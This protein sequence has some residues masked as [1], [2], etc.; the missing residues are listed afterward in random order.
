[1]NSLK[2]RRILLIDDMPPIHEDFRKI[3]VGDSPVSELD[4]VEAMLFGT[5][6]DT[7]F[8]GFELDS[9]YQG[10]DGMEMVQKSLD[11]NLPYAMAFIDMRMPP[12]WDGVETTERLWQLDP[13][14]QIVIC[15]AYSD[16]SW[17]EVLTRLDTRDRLL[18]LKKPFDLIEV[19]QLANT[20]TAKWVSGQQAALKMEYLEQIVQERTKE[21]T[22]EMLVRK[23]AQASLEIANHNLQESEEQYRLLVE[24]SPDA[25]LI[26]R[27]ERV[28]FANR[29]ACDMFRVQQID[30]LLNRSIASLFVSPPPSAT[31]HLSTLEKNID[32]Q[33]LA[34]ELVLC[35]D[36]DEIHV[37]VTRLAYTY[38]GKSATQ[39]V[40]RDA[41][42]HK[43]VQ[44][45]LQYQ[46]NYDAL[47]GLPNR[48]LLMDRLHQ[49]L[50]HAQ[51]NEG[52]L[53]ICFL[54]LDRFKWI[55]DNL[56]HAAG[57]ELLKIVA[58]R[59]GACLRE[60]DTI[61]RLGGDE[62]VLL[63]YNQNGQAYDV[64]LAIG[65]VVK[66]VAQP[67]IL[68]G[69][70]VNISCS[71]G[72]SNFPEDGIDGN[73]LLKF[74]DAAMYRAKKMGRNNLQ[75]YNEN[76]H[77]HLDE[78]KK[79][80][81]DLQRAI[82][83]R[84]LSLAYQ[85]QIDLR[86]GKIIGAE[87]LLRWQHPELGNISPSLFLP[88]AE[89]T[90]LIE[91][92]GAWTIRTVCEQCKEWREAD[93]PTLCIS[94]NLSA[95]QVEWPD[96]K[97][98]I[99]DCLATNNIEPCHIELELAE[100]TIVQNIEKIILIMNDL[101][102]L[103]VQ[104]AIDDFGTGYSNL[105]SLAALPIDKIK[106]DGSFINDVVS[107]PDNLAIANTIIVMAH[108]L[109]LK[110]V[111]EMVETAGQV[112]LLTLGG[113]DQAQGYFFSPALQAPELMAFLQAG[114]LLVP[115]PRSKDC[116]TRTLLVLDDDPGM[117][118]AVVRGLRF[119]GYRVLLANRAE[120]AFELLA[121][122]N[123]GVVL[124]DQRLQETTGVEMLTKIRRLYPGTV[125]LL[126]S[127]YKEFDAMTAAINQGAIY[128][129]LG[130]PFSNH[131]LRKI[132]AEAFEVYDRNVSETRRQSEA[133]IA[134]S[135]LN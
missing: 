76:L 87:A 129:F 101:K 79:L 82:D 124:C 19:R 83:E 21:L 117:T 4:D 65:R 85:P 59:I 107:S 103:G 73:E 118:R 43:R 119:D 20:L 78:R 49:A 123:I 11:A 80:A 23:E 99:A 96:L 38:Q 66:S 9:A 45:Q 63:L 68:A 15:T 93:L 17:E 64:E 71:I 69:R 130:K 86:N 16:Y 58:L 110:T 105:R 57:D 125:R 95:K 8:V 52:R 27:S 31:V 122:N 74:A 10:Q 39:L 56:G 81:T 132:L 53:A 98:C 14:L 42:E 91:S 134:K 12:G 114:P 131:E 72:C 60:T 6:A 13:R 22:N 2:N 48:H 121:C 111:A 115:E 67:L 120:E 100:S 36:G 28:V 30:D 18:I 54:D 41:T 3:L 40:I 25:I 1:M 26:E 33:L 109:G 88:L 34:E 7:S 116:F 127:G 112:A 24:L 32:T 47:T 94:I 128:K 90:G 51:R 61:A 102:S 55:N 113:C 70:A 92:L 46:A 108:Q 62:F 77:R 5:K 97:Q 104:L 29:T 37:L 75:I 133:S 50:S 89:E 135:R 106:L 35:L 126:F 44:K 84:Q